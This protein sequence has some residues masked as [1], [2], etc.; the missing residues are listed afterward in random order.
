[1]C[2][3][4][5]QTRSNDRFFEVAL[6]EKE[7]TEFFVEEGVGHVLVDLFK[8]AIMEDVTIHCSSGSRK[9]L[10]TCSISIS[11][12]CSCKNFVLQPHSEEHMKRAVGQRLSSLLKELFVTVEPGDVTFRHFDWECEVDA[13][14]ASWA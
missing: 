13:I 3:L 4:Q 6:D 1:M 11:A 14:L 7:K 5:I 8:E 9:G 12:Q 10:H 2:I